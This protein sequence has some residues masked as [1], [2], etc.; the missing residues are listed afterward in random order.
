MQSMSVKQYLG[1]AATIVI[2]VNEKREKDKQRSVT[3]RLA[4]LEDKDDSED[5]K[6]EGEIKAVDSDNEQT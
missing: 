6:F 2:V 1:L 3:T 5:E 4:H